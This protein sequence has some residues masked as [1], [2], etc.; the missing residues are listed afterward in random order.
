MKRMKHGSVVSRLFSAGLALAMA[1]GTFGASVMPVSAT[2]TDS[3]GDGAI[4]VQYE[5]EGLKSD[6]GGFYAES[7]STLT[8]KVQVRN[9]LQSDLED[10]DIHVNIPEGTTLKDENQR[11]DY[12]LDD[13][14]STEYGQDGKSLKF[15]IPVVVNYGITEVGPITFDLSYQTADGGVASGTLPS[16]GNRESYRV[17]LNNNDPTPVEGGSMEISVDSMSMANPGEEVTFYFEAKSI[18]GFAGEADITVM[19]PEGFVLRDSEP[20]DVSERPGNVEYVDVN[21]GM[22]YQLTEVKADDLIRFSVTGIAPDDLEQDTE[23]TGSVVLDW[24][25]SGNVVQPTGQD[26]KDITIM[27]KQKEVPPIGPVIA[28][29]TFEPAKGQSTDVKPGV[30]IKMNMKL[31]LSSDV[32]DLESVKDATLTVT[33][34]SGMT[35]KEFAA[36]GVRGT[37]DGDM[38]CDIKLGDLVMGREIN[39]VLTLVPSMDMANTRQV[40][41]GVA[42]WEDGKSEDVYVYFDI[43]DGIDRVETVPKLSLAWSDTKKTEERTYQLGEELPV[44]VS[45]VNNNKT[46]VLDGFVRLTYPSDMEVK[47]GSYGKGQLFVDASGNKMIEWE[48]GKLKAD[49]TNY[50]EAVFVAAKADEDAASKAGVFSATMEYSNPPKGEES[51]VVSGN[52]LT[53]LR[54]MPEADALSVVVSQDG[55]VEDI[56]VQPGQKVVYTLTAYN[57]GEVDMKNVKVTGFLP[58]GFTFGK[59]DTKAL[60]ND[61]GA[62]TWTIDKLEAGKKAE[63]NFGVTV[64]TNVND[65]STTFAMNVIAKA[66]EV[67]SVE[68][69]TV[70]MTVGEGKVS[71]SLWQK[72]DGMDESTRDEM[73]VE[74]GESFKYVM[75]VSNS[76]TA[77][78][79]EVNVGISVPGTLKIGS[80]LGENMTVEGTNYVWKIYDLEEGK[81]VRG[82]LEVTAPEDTSTRSATSNSGSSAG[83][84]NK[85]ARTKTLKVSA[86]M[87]WKDEAGAT[88]RQTSNTVTTIIKEDVPEV[89]WTSPWDNQNKIDDAD[90][91]PAPKVNNTGLRVETISKTTLTHM[92]AYANSDTIVVKASY[93]KLKPNTRYVGTVGLVNASGGMM[94]DINGN[95]CSA[96]VDFTTTDKTAGDIMTVEFTIAGKDYVGRCLYGAM[97]VTPEGGQKI[98]YRGDGFEESTIRSAKVLGV[99]MN[100]PTVTTTNTGH[101]IATVKY[102]NVQPG[103]GY[104]VVAVLMDRTTKKPLVTA[105]GKAVSGTADFTAAE[106]S[107]SVDVPIMYGM[108]DIKGKDLALYVTLYDRDGKVVLAVDQDINKAAGSGS[109]GVGQTVYATAK[110][111]EDMGSE[112]GAGNVLPIV[113]ASAAVVVILATFGFAAHH[114]KKRKDGQK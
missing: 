63:V 42:T 14:L 104:Q 56:K 107:G 101:G 24:T 25:H 1:I 29:F 79:G 102:E 69:N 73:T 13:F 103:Q 85:T 7:G 51:T 75:L 59:A 6:T 50:F 66:D 110:T 61:D 68:S 31:V 45:V 36:P 41:G 67:D 88:H 48:A 38:K 19:L 106:E 17:P 78:V 10:I 34:P 81:T 113:M 15:E 49:S 93:T 33:V 84:A 16:A 18:N 44:V 53:A 39:A 4:S 62:I 54:L 74:P 30:D 105:Q 108:D 9:E 23:L 47:E 111:G 8:Y 3:G 71:I 2:G 21:K 35:V 57:T 97:D 100:N 89:T 96:H 94:K 27:V 83:T 65:N 52:Y 40:V 76:G 98:A 22:N 112:L 72:K 37:M 91:K 28:D 87:A 60:V 20:W 70:S 80:D 5:V 95:D 90:K 58:T 109:N 46:N 77:T 92:L 12:R 32:E 82:E 99:A 55:T 64:P 26:A 43:N 11:V 86:K 114:D